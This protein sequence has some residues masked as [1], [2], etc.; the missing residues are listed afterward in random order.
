MS[1]DKQNTITKC[2]LVFDYRCYA[3]CVHYEKKLQKNTI[4]LSFQI[5]ERSREPES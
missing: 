5:C 2:N 1:D 4:K 3:Y